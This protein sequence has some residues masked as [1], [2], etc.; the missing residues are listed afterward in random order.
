[1]TLWLMAAGFVG[2]VVA[3]HAVTARRYSPSHFVAELSLAG[4]GV[5]FS[6]TPDGVWW[7]VRFGGRRCTTTFPA[8]WGDAPPDAG[9]REQR[10]PPGR[11][12]LNAAAA[13]Q[14]PDP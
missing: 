10:R 1:M 5:F 12:P 9:V 14:P 2:G 6:R 13:S 3:A 8:D 4:R 7:R 11:G